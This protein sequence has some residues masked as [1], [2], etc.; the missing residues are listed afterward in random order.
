MRRPR[1]SENEIASQNTWSKAAVVAKLRGSVCIY[2]CVRLMGWIM[3]PRTPYTSAL[4]S[5]CADGGGRIVCCA[6]RNNG[7]LMKMCVRVCTPYQNLLLSISHR[8]AAI[9][10]L[11]LTGN[12]IFSSAQR[13]S[14]LKIHVKV[15]S[16]SSTIIIS[17]LFFTFKSRGQEIISAVWY[18]IGNYDMVIM[19]E[20]TNC[21]FSLFHFGLKEQISLFLF[22]VWRN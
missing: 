6:M 7:F 14:K 19:T 4:F 11:L 22:S 16:V 18:F 2:M 17:C 9:W 5:L 15:T 20:I 8:K 3:P 10:G 1:L 12:W 13:C 21:R